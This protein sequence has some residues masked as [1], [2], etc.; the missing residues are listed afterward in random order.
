MAE[1]VRPALDRAQVPDFEVDQLL[2]GKVSG[3]G[4]GSALQ[5][6]RCT[7]RKNHFFE[8]PDAHMSAALPLIVEDGEIGLV[9]LDRAIVFTIDGND[10]HA[11]IRVTILEL[12]DT[13][14]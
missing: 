12:G 11:D 7:R 13:G 6:G 5:I 10:P 8:Q 4:E 14:Q 9:V 2:P 1:P 3:A